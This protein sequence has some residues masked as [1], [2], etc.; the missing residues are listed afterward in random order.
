MKV[1]ILCGGMGTRLRGPG[2]EIPK[3]LAEVDGKPLIWHIMKIYNR[4][5]FM[6]FILPLG[7]GGD[8]IKEYFY[9]YRWKNFDFT[10][11]I[12][13]NKIS[14]HGE[15][16]KWNITFVDTGLKTLTGSR[17]KRVEKY[18]DED[19]FMMTYGDGLSDV[20]I[21]ELLDYH[22]K[23]GKTATVTGIKRKSQFGILKV[24][25]GIAE[26]FQEKTS[27]EGVINGGFFVL[28]KKIFNYIDNDNNCT[29][30]QEPMRNLVKSRELAVY[31]HDGQWMAIDTYKDLILANKLWKF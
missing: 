20:N 12:E 11:N 17:I 19:T 29:F 10:L 16:E 28:N 4:Y 24:Q 7:F 30:E 15:P 1:V 13:S 5:G 31:M 18:I 23:M 26:D 22:I 14:L 25:N 8:K 6:D 2:E 21:G 3:P 27:L 9:N